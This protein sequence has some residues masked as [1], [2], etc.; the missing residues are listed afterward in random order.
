M[1]RDRPVEQRAGL[2]TYAWH[3][4]SSFL[5][6]MNWRDFCLVHLSGEWDHAMGQVEAEVCLLGCWARVVYVYD[7]NT[8]QQHRIREALDELE[9]QRRDARAISLHSPPNPHHDPT[10]S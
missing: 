10:D 7:A 9:Q 6:G 2:F 3:T 8:P 5:P 1:T 4:Y